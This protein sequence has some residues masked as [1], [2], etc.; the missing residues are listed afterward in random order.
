MKKLILVFWWAA[1]VGSHYQ[2]GFW[3]DLRDLHDFRNYLKIQVV[4]ETAS[5]DFVDRIKASEF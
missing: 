4:M 3:V 1:V 5:S 2:V